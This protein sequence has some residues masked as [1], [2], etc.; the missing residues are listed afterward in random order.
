MPA[1]VIAATS[2]YASYSANIDGAAAG[3]IWGC[4]AC[5]SNVKTCSGAYS[6]ASASVT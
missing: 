3:G 4:V 5:G 6:S 1:S 2:S